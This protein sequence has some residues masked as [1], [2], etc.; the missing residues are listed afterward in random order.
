MRILIIEDEV[1]TAKALALLIQAIR[2]DGDLSGPLQTVEAAVKYLLKNQTPDLIFMD[3]QLADGLCFE[4]FKSVKVTA[5]VIFCTAY[6]QYAIEA[7]KANG[8]AYILKPFSKDSLAAAFEKVTLLKSHYSDQASLL[9]QLTGLLNHRQEFQG[10]QSFLVTKQ[11]KYLTIP[12]ETIAF[13]YVRNE[14]ATIMTSD[15][16]EYALA[17]SL[18]EITASLNPTQF[19]RV[20]R[21]YL[22]SFK[23][24]IEV[25]HYF[26]RKLLVKMTPATPETLLVG[27]DKTTAFLSWLEKR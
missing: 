22:I 1:K 15:G 9:D 12:T 23:A 26:A 3:I 8:V 7:F 6:D 27:K 20:N 19:F 25:E 18:D 24:I 11:H 16:Q 21:Q 17:Q 4:I 2:P 10:K 14:S 13:F 5:P